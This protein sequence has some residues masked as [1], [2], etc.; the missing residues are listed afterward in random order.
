MKRTVLV[1]LTALGVTTAAHAQYSKAIAVV[2]NNKTT[3][4]Q[5]LLAVKAFKQNEKADDTIVSK[6]STVFKY[7]YKK[8]EAIIVDTDKRRFSLYKER[9]KKI[10]EVE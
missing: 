8:Y 10:V 5:R 4:E 3:D 6:D 9:N 7:L 1:L 2:S